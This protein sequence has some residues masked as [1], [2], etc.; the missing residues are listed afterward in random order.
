MKTHASTADVSLENFHTKGFILLRDVLEPTVVENTRTAM[1]IL[2]DRA[3]DHLVS[4]GRISDRLRSDPFET[5][6][7]HLYKNNLDLA[8]KLFREELHMAEL[9]RVFFNSSLLDVAE[10][11]LG[12]EIRLYPN[13]T[14]RPKL[15][16]WAGTLVLWHQDGGYTESSSEGSVNELRMV[17][18]WSPL[19]K[20]TRANGCMLFIPGTH[21]LGTVPHVKKE[22]DTDPT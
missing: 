2:V 8:P 1:M 16:D 6:L 10:K 19:V 21:K 15:P 20:A 17:N 9:Y 18:V 22:H 4:L 5:R 11:I 3:A 7:Y 13:Y 12:P 14:V